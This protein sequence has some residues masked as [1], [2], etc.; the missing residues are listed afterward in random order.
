MT[1]K[2]EDGFGEGRRPEEA[3][4]GAAEGEREGGEAGEGG[5]GEDETAGGKIRCGKTARS[6]TRRRR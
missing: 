5:E 3:A 4:G 1:K 2:L 6:V